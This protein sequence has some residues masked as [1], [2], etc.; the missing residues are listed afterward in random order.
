MTLSSDV[1]LIRSRPR[2][3]L[4]GRGNSQQKVKAGTRWENESKQE[5]AKGPGEARNG[6]RPCHVF[7]A[8]VRGLGNS[9]KEEKA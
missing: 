1:T 7:K 3:D 9:F 8:V 4:G 5:E 2:G 6:T